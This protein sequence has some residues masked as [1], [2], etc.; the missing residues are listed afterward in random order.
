MAV[1][2]QMAEPN[3]CQLPRPTDAQGRYPLIGLCQVLSQLPCPV[4][5]SQVLHK[6]R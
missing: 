4:R 5:L 6:S 3:H 2:L 1:S